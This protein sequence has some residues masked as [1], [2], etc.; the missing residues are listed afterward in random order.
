MNNLQFIIMEFQLHIVGRRLSYRRE[1][2]WNIEWTLKQCQELKGV[3]VHRDVF[4]LYVEQRHLF[5]LDKCFPC[6]AQVN[7]ENRSNLSASIGLIS[8]ADVF[9]FAAFVHQH[10]DDAGQI[11][12]WRQSLIGWNGIV[13]DRLIE[14]PSLR[15]TV[16][17]SLQMLSS[18]N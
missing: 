2:R 9:V 6:R 13:R 14:V 5:Y 16:S 4:D 17:S 3:L 18:P 15:C 10:D 1:I 7:E 8:R 12:N 11:S